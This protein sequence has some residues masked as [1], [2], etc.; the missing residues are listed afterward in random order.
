MSQTIDA[1]TDRETALDG[2][3]RA[4]DEL[5]A[6]FSDVPDAALTY[7]PEGD[8]YALGGLVLHVTQ[9]LEHYTH[10]LASIRSG[11]F[12][13]VRVPADAEEVERRRATRLKAGLSG[14][15]RPAVI[16]ALRSAH[17]QLV[18]G[19]RALSSG[20]YARKAPVYFG[21]ASE[22]DEIGAPDILGW[23]TDHYRDHTRQVA[24]LAAAWKSATG[25]ESGDADPRR[26]FESERMRRAREVARG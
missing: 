24:D 10:V 2:F 9:V 19:V 17:D 1:S 5:E 3:A 13:E 21:D 6:A 16:V 7:C 26:T 4:R 12:G 25:R 14:D 18:A 23:M 8:D 22:P 11:E 20:Q 15:Q